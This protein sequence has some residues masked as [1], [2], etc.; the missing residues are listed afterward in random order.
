VAVIFS[1]QS[2]LIASVI[3]IETMKPSDN[4][5]IKE[6]GISKMVEEYLVGFSDQNLPAPV[7]KFGPKVS[8]NYIACIRF[9][10]TIAPILSTAQSKSN[11]Y[12]CHLLVFSQLTVHC[13]I[14][15]LY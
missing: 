6:P 3:H 12:Y 9:K 7:S 4:F 13:D 5:V 8:R 15:W 11:I 14:A 1:C 2:M 10:P